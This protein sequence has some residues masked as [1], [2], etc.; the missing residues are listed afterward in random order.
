M[1]VYNLNTLSVDKAKKG[2]RVHRQNVNILSFHLDVYISC[3]GALNS[4]L[5]GLTVDG[6]EYHRGIAIATYLAKENGNFGYQELNELKEITL[7]I[8]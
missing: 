4:I 8:Y 1:F 6:E 2:T 3:S 5:S 7:E